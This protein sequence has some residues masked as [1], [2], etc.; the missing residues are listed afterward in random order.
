MQMTDRDAANTHEVIAEIF[1]AMSLN[2]SERTF[3]EPLPRWAAKFPYVNGGLFSDAGSVPKLSRVARSYLVQ[4]ATLDWRLVNPDIFGSMIQG[5]ANDSERANLGMHYTSVPNILKALNSLFLDDVRRQLKES[6]GNPRKLLDLK[7]RLARTCVF[8]P[9]C[10]SG[11]FL[12]IAYKQLREIEQ[13]INVLILL[14]S[15]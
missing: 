10:G 5:V 13:E 12:L 8:D 7:M 9:A 14:H 1:R 4:I 2:A 3:A 15:H 6:R 11:N